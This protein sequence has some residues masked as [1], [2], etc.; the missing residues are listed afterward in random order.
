[1]KKFKAAVAGIVALV[2]G[3]IVIRFALGVC[4]VLIRNR[5]P[6][7]WFTDLIEVDALLLATALSICLAWYVFRYTLKKQKR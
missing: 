4:A 2:F 5:W 1:M 6:G 7:A 3:F